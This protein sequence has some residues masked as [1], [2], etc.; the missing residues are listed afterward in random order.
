MTT[1]D[2][3]L[4]WIDAHEAIV[5]RWRGGSAALERLAS[6]VPD[7]RRSTGH[8]RQRPGLVSGGAVA[9]RP[10][11]DPHRQEHVRR[12]IDSV[13]AHLPPDDDLCVV[14]PGRLRLRLE[15]RIRHEDLRHGRARVLRGEA[16]GRM[17]DAQ[18]V[19]RLRLAVGA[20]PRRRNVGPGA[21]STG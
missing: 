19:A 1:R 9:P 17:T 6:E 16:A 11:D 14:G 13:I 7:H 5:A 15:R 4:V 12:F 10:T 20:A 3:T 21:S 18:L 2:T 8:V